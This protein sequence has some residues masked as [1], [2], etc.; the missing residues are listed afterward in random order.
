MGAENDGDFGGM[1]DEP[2]VD[3]EALCSKILE[4]ALHYDSLFDKA[5]IQTIRVKT[6][7]NLT[8]LERLR[9]LKAEHKELESQLRMAQL[10][11][12]CKDVKKK[13]TQES[14]SATKARV[15]ELRQIVQERNA[16]GDR[17]EE[18]MPQQLHDVEKSDNNDGRNVEAALLWYRNVLGFCTEGGEVKL[19]IKILTRSTH[20]PYG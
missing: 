11:K 7:Q 8:D 3:V 14:I 5:R 15:E 2:E 9:K 20:L 19:I 6:E 17:I 16:M 1:S 18:V 4:K 13:N 12:K 10:R